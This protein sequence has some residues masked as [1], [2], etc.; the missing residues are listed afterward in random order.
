MGEARAFIGGT[1]VFVRMRDG[2]WK[3]KHLVDVKG[4]PGM[5][6]LT[7]IPAVGLR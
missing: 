7:F 3:D 2:V 5:N 4:L 6:D 1:D